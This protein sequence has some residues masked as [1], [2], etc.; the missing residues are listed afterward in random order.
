LHGHGRVAGDSE[1]GLRRGDV[2]VFLFLF[3]FVFLFVFVTARAALPEGGVGTVNFDGGIDR[4]QSRSLA[5]NVE[6]LRL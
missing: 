2:R 4:G 1:D 6:A 5:L 3:L